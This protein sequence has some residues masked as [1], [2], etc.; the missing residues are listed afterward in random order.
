MRKKAFMVGIVM[1]LGEST[2][3]VR[4][5]GVLE[6]TG[7]AFGVE[8]TTFE[9]PRLIAVCLFLQFVC[10]LFVSSCLYLSCHPVEAA[11]FTHVVNV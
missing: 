2:V 4:L 10:G 11:R 8:S 3:F 7:T 6:E 1:G 5:K 9:P